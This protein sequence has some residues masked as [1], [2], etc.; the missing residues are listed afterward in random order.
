MLEETPERA[1]ALA[2]RRRGVRDPDAKKTK[3]EELEAQ[4][5]AAKAKR[6]ELQGKFEEEKKKLVAALDK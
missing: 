1:L 3:P 2:E 4:K 6:A 5:A